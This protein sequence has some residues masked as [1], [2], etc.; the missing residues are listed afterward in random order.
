[1]HVLPLTIALILCASPL[2]SAT[3]QNHTESEFDSSSPSLLAKALDSIQRNELDKAEKQIELYL[4]ENEP[5][6]KSEELL[7][8]IDSLKGDLETGLSHFEKAIKLDPFQA[9]A[10]TKAGDVYQAKGNI[11]NAKERF[12]QALMINK[13][14]RLANQRLGLILESENNIAEAIKHL[15]RGL[16]GTE[17]SYVGVKVNLGLLYNRIG[18]FKKTI[19]LLEPILQFIDNNPMGLL[20]AGVASVET[21]E[22]EQG[23]TLLI[24][25][26]NLPVESPQVSIMIG[27]ALSSANEAERA[28]KSFKSAIEAGA[29]PQSL[30]PEIAKALVRNQDREGAIS[31]LA[32]DVKSGTK[33]VQTYSLLAS[34]YQEDQNYS[35]AENTIRTGIENIDEPYMLKFRLGTH[36][37]LI[38]NYDKAREILTDL[39][40]EKPEDWQ[41]AKTLSMVELRSGHFDRAITAAKQFVNLTANSSDAL[42]YYATILEEAGK[43]KEAETA[44]KSVLNTDPNNVFALNNLANIFVESGNPEEAQDLAQKAIDLA[45]THPMIIDT[46][47]WTK[48]HLGEYE[49]AREYLEK[50]EVTQLASPS[51]Q[52][53]LAMVYL[54]LEQRDEALKHLVSALESPKPFPARAEAEELRIKLEKK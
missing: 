23:K 13:D 39:L 18:E 24:K 43:I 47:A 16:I 36:F 26:C 5:N 41:V 54:K 28:F 11:D 49:S 53:H 22:T 45:P 17:A 6:A 48:Y 35:K 12:S 20:V 31:L 44:Y 21:G 40:N 38:R 10:Y 34:L 33:N 32:D 42:F 8:T 14:D 27:I 4:K 9:T 3:Y 25:A 46:L 7:G 51:H 37:A 50:K 2:H 1:M 52:Y 19:N 29:D 30:S 15:E